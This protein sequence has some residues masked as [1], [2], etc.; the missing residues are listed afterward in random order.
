[1]NIF[2]L[3]ASLRFQRFGGQRYET[4]MRLWEKSPG[5]ADGAT[6]GV[7]YQITVLQ[8]LQFG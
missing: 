8:L 5:A 4:R 6:P 1:M 7:Q 2:A 3:F